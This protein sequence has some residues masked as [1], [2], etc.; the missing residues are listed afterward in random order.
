MA[1]DYKAFIDELR[2][3]IGEGKPYLTSP[4][5]ATYDWLQRWRTEIQRLLGRIEKMG[6]DHDCGIEYRLFEAQQT[7]T[8]D[9]R[10]KDHL[11]AFRQDMRD[12]LIELELLVAEYDKHGDPHAPPAPPSEAAT[13][14]GTPPSADPLPLKL[15]EKI[16]IAW[17]RD[18]V[19]VGW[20]W[21]TV[22]GAIAVFAAG[23]TTGAWLKP[24]WELRFATRNHQDLSAPLK[25]MPQAAAPALTTSVP[26]STPS[27]KP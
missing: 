4:D 9:P 19:P 18:H 5:T 15:P 23:F 7:Y 13:S 14:I 1:L 16:T 8:F 11:A 12:T 21:S 26:A 17:L 3:L 25:A 10:P 27:A 6:Y 24:W 2:R 22:L 20:L